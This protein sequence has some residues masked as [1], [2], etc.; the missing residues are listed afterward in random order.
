MR[1]CHTISDRVVSVLEK[2]KAHGV[3]IAL[4]TGRPS[5]AANDI[6][7]QLGVNAPSMYFSGS[8]IIDHRNREFLDLIELKTATVAKII[9]F[10]SRE[11]IPCE[12]YDSSDYYIRKK[13]PFAEL[14]AHYLGKEAI[15]CSLEEITTPILKG[16]FIL[17]GEEREEKISK[18]KQAFQSE[19]I[20]IAYGAAH[21]EIS[22]VNITSPKAERS[23]AFS[24]IT[25]LLEVSPLEVIAFGDGQ[26]DM[27][28]LRLAGCGVAM[29]NAPDE[30]KEA[31]DVTT[32]HVENDGVASFL[33]SHLDRF[34]N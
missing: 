17:N 2:A 9:E 28:F 20:G 12:L 25:E 4:A 21:K 7:R 18:I 33:E 23:Y 34:F 16:V 26:S 8:C 15:E 22:Y 29:G 30:V 32:E 31:A 13:S 3:K 27:P 14:H 10:A 5:F 24:R 6:V 1:K 19:T 11:E